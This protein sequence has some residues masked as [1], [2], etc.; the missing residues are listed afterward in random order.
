VSP[1]EEI[2]AALNAS[3]TRCVIVG[4][5]AVNLHG[6]QRFTQDLDIV[7]DLEPAR[8]RRRRSRRSRLPVRI[9]DFADAETRERWIRERQMVVFQMYDEGRRLTVDV[10]VRYP[11]PFEE[12][13]SEASEIMLPQSRVRIASIRHLIHMKREAG[14]PQDLADVSALETI[15][16]LLTDDRAAGG[17]A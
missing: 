7:I 10:F 15:L 3:G 9:T 6:H 2:F 1:F 17:G 13:W 5:V 14:R 8:A 16:D 11:L 4:G 12:L